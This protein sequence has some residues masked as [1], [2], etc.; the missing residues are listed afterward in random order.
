[1]GDMMGRARHAGQWFRLEAD[2][3]G[4][5]ADVY[6]YAEIGD[7]FW[8]DAVSARS[9]A[10]QIDQI[11]A[12]VIRVFV[13]SPGGAA[14]DGIT[15]MNALRRHPARIEVTVD[16]IAASAASVVAMAGDLITVNRGS[17]MMV[18]DASGGAWGDAQTM[19]DT[20]GILHKLSDSIADVYAAR[21][22]GTRESWR[23]IMQE[24]SWYTAEEAV[25]AG[26]ADEWSDAPAQL[27][28]GV[29]RN[30]F[31]LSVFAH[32]G[33]SRAPAPRIEDIHFPSPTGPGTTNRRETAMAYG[34]LT[35]GMRERLGVTD[36]EASDETLLAALDAALARPSAPQV[37]EGATLIDSAALANL[38]QAAEDGR[39]AR[40]RQD[41][42]RRDGIVA[43]AVKDG[44]IAPASHDVWRA[45]LDADE[46]GTAGLLQSLA[47]NTVPVDEIGH[48]E[49]PSEDEQLYAKAWGK[50]G[51]VA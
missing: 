14:W 46:D 15:I 49:A 3:A 37:P 25:Q 31:D 42:D 11:S 20:A 18:H 6:I 22:G 13:N 21:A 5:S 1:M 10:E 43:Q 48:Q 40:I 50:D 2:P 29:P 23:A 19:E 32:A 27:P 4:E 28:E 51:E 24:E 45:Q 39:Q 47:V 7:D 17:M 26:L 16:G 41:K 9:L 8:G 34:D 30:K 35:A 12:P 44:R 38:Q 33:R 36:A